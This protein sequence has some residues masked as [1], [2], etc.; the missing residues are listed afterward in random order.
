MIVLAGNA[1]V[2]KAAKDAGVSTEVPFS[3]GRNDARQDQTEIEY[4][5]NQD[6]IDGSY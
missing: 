1:A 4:I 5:D 6:L 2:E 3:P